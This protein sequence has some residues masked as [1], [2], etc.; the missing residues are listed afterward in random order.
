M[1][2]ALT[3]SYAYSPKTSLEWD[4]T[5]PIR[6]FNS[7]ISSSGVTL[8]NLLNYDYS[9]ENPCRDWGY[10]GNTSGGRGTSTDTFEQ[11]IVRIDY[12]SSL[13]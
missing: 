4:L 13:L 1:T 12:R 3:S 9:I 7:A 2:I 6:E 11:P 8:T 5:V 10:P